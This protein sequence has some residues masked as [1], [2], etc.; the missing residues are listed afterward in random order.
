MPFAKT[1]GR[2]DTYK[3]EGKSHSS[4]RTT[5]LTFSTLDAASK[6]V[7]VFQFQSWLVSPDAEATTR[8]PGEDASADLSYSRVQVGMI[9]SSASPVPKARTT[10]LIANRGRTA[11]VFWLYRAS[12]KA[13]AL[14][15][16]RQC[17]AFVAGSGSR[18]ALAG[19]FNSSS[20]SEMPEVEA[21]AGRLGVGE[22]PA[23]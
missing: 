20:S 13:E 16:C 12:H 4:Q 21:K 9:T 6:K 15:E 11:L 14:S 5:C 8:L 7:H 17:S 1:Q 23:G 22:E 3:L 18:S 10:C 2:S 19:I